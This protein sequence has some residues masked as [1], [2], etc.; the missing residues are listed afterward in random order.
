MPGLAECTNCDTMKKTPNFP[1]PVCSKRHYT[2]LQALCCGDA[3]CREIIAKERKLKLINIR[4][5]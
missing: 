1:C 5:K 4:V 3:D 2:L